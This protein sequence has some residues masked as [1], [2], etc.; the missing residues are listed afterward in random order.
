[1]YSIVLRWAVIALILLWVCVLAAPYLMPLVLG[2]AANVDITAARSLI[3]G[4]WF[5]F[6]ILATTVVISL[7]LLHHIFK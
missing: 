2:R 1:M 4:Y 7:A 5:I 6:T 3:W